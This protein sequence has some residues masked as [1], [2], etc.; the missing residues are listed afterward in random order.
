[1]GMRILYSF[2]HKIGADRICHTAWQH[3]QGLASAGIDVH[4]MPAA[5]ARPLAARTRPT[6]SRG[7]YRI[8][9]RLIGK[10]RAFRLHDYIVARRLERLAREIDLVHVWPCGALETIKTAKR[11]GIP[12]VLERPNAH[13]RYAYETVRAE[14]ERIGVRLSPNDEYNYRSEVLER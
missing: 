14:C 4:A 5:L 3:V 12:V 6:L 13:T 2:P 9:F 1:M 7:K 8:P 11:L 10:Y